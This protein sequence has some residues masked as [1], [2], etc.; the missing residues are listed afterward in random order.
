MSDPFAAIRAQLPAVRT[1]RRALESGRVASSYL[2]EGPSGVDKQRAALALAQTL[3]AGDDDEA[4]RRIAEGRHSDVRV[5]EPRAE[6]HGNIQVETLRNDILPFAQFAPFEAKAAFLIFPQADVSFPQTHPEAANALLKTLEEPRAGVHFVLLSERPDRLLPT[7]RS[8][9]QSVR[10]SRL[11]LEVVDDILKQHGVADGERGPAL[12]LCDGRADRAL[13]L[14]RDGTGRELL[15]LALEVD[16]AI[17][18]RK[19][20]TLVDAAERLAK[21]DDLPLAL[22][23]LSTLYRDVACAVLGLGDDALAFRHAADRVRERAS[24]LDAARA[25]DRV[26]RIRETADALEHNANAEIAVDA[27]LFELR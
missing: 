23:T 17:G 15:E 12:A 4:A 8:R 14:A 9:C 20:G 26:A 3:V 18:R 10:F 11:P 16:A 19:P 2:F 25:A 13:A 7:I 6:G 5:F 1:L 22:E 21:S 27:L 24:A